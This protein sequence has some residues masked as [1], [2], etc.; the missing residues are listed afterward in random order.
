MADF[1]TEAER[2]RKLYAICALILLAGLFIAPP[3]LVMDM[4]ATQERAV[5]T[6]LGQR[7]LDA[8]NRPAQATATSLIKLFGIRYLFSSQHA[9][10]RERG[11][12]FAMTIYAATWRFIYLFFTALLSCGILAAAYYDGL[13]RRKLAQWRYEYASPVKHFVA[14]NSVVRMLE[15]TFL[16]MFIPL[17]IPPLFLLPWLLAFGMAM[18]TWAANLQERM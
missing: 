9:Y 8:I 6:Q 11:Q 18:R 7:S 15:L 1:K 10:F 17:P 16:A 4:Q 3:S 12:V 13:R 14:R 2:H 5:K